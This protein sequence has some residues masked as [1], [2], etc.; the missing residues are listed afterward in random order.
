MSKQYNLLSPAL[1]SG[2]IAFDT[3][4]ITENTF[5]QLKKLFNKYHKYCNSIIM[6]EPI[7][8]LY[9]L[10]KWKELPQVYNI[11]S[12]DFNFMYPKC[13]KS[14]AL[15]LHDTD[16]RDINKSP[17][18]EEWN[19]NF[20]NADNIDTKKPQITSAVWS[21]AEESLYTIILKIRTYLKIRKLFI[22]YDRSIGLLGFLLK[23]NFLKIINFIQASEI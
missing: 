23:I 21:H 6:D 8:N 1:K 22:I 19:I 9:F 7:F 11:N 5:H 13:V 20:L 10:G 12:S 18:Y 3:N 16:K 2:V 15:H 14:I 17:Y 4:I